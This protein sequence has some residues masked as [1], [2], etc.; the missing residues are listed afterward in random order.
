M[1]ASQTNRLLRNRAHFLFLLFVSII[2]LQDRQW[3]L[4]NL[5][6]VIHYSLGVSSN[7]SLCILQKN[8][9]YFLVINYS[10]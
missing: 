8:F 1:A 7:Y 9:N 4:N 10:Q 2:S 5:T 3:K 6:S